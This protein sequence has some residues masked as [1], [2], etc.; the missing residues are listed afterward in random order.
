MGLQN[1]S[2]EGDFFVPECLF[3]D[4]THV[5][6]EY[7]HLH[8]IQALI[9][10]VDNTL[11]SHGSQQL[12]PSVASWIMHMK[13]H[14]IQM[15][16]AS[17]NYKKRVQPFADKIGLPFV[18]FACKPSSLGLSTARRLLNRPK[19]EIALVGDQIFTD[20]LAGK[21]YGIQVLLVRPLVRDTKPS[22]R[23]KRLLES[24]ILLRYYRNGGEI[25]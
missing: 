16:V 15:I 11:T 23:L 7:L 3:R 14:G 20:L 9:L 21:L 8:G 25:L 22:I 6:L 5:S 19:K 4:I 13:N 10:D 2:P 1:R 18:S 12:S 17:N 24:P